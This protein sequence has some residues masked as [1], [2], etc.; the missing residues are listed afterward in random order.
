MKEG[1]RITPAAIYFGLALLLSTLYG[2]ALS[3]VLYEGIF[4]A[5]AWLGRPA[6]ALG[7]AGLTAMAGA[8]LWRLL[9]GHMPSQTVFTSYLPLGYALFWLFDPAIDLVRSRLLTGGSLWLFVAL[10]LRHWPFAPEQKKYQRLLG[11]MLLVLALLPIYLLTMPD[12]VGRADT[13][14]FQVVTPRLGIVHPTGYPLYLILGKLFT[15]VPIGSIAWRLNFSSAVFAIGAALFIFLLGRRLVFQTLPALLGALILGLLPTFWSQAIEAEVYALNALIVAAALYFMAV[16]LPTEDDAGHRH[17][18]VTMLATGRRPYLLLALTLGV[19][20][21]HHLTTLF[22]FPPAALTLWF[23]H[24]LRGEKSYLN[25]R[26]LLQM[27]LLIVAPL[28]F[29]L[30]LPVRWAA[31]NGEPMG[32]A[33][34][35]DWVIGGRFQGALQ[36][37]AWLRDPARFAIVGRLFL[38]E[39]G[40]INLA[41]AA[42]GW[43]ALYH[44]NRRYSFVA[45]LMWGGYTFYS[46]NY[47]V[48][49]LAVFLLPAQIA[50]ALGWLALPALLL[51]VTGKLPT[52]LSRWQPLTALLPAILSLPVIV[53]AATHWRAVDRTADDGRA[54]WGS[55]VLEQPLV[56]NAAI[57]AD[58]ERFPPLYYRQQAEGV[59]PD[60]DIVV[61]PDEDAYRA[62]LDARLAAGQTVYLARQLPGLSGSYH[63]RSAGPLVEV[64]PRPLEEP[65]PEAMPATLTA[66]PLGLVAFEVVVGTAYGLGETDGRPVTAVTLYWQVADPPAEALRVYLRW[67]DSPAT[68]GQH[69]ANNSYPTNAWHPGEVVADFHVL[70]QPLLGTPV[71]LPLQVAVGPPFS[72][73][74]TL[75]WKTISEISLP[76]TTRLIGA[77]PLRITATPG[78]LTGVEVPALVRP[79]SD[80][81]LAVA[82]QG[83]AAGWRVNWADAEPDDSPAPQSPAGSGSLFVMSTILRAP[84]IADVYQV[85]A[86][87]A[88]AVRCGWLQPPASHCPVGS[89]TV[90]GVPLPPDAIN[91]DDK[92]ALLSLAIPQTTLTPGTFLPVSVQWQAL[93][94]LAQDYTVFVQL[95]DGEGRLVGQVDT[96]PV[97]GT[98]PTSR[99]R[100]GTVVADAYQLPIDAT[101]PPGP[102][103]L[104]IGFYL[105]ATGRRLPVLDEAGRPRDDRYIVSGL[106]VP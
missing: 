84:V 93:A 6:G 94:S 101:L 51:D 82:G 102:Y 90:S 57:L 42:V 8:L 104:Q 1:R 86:R 81:M 48:P 28:A 54:A 78:A 24:R 12:G 45:L 3:R 23:A 67:E 13:F 19:G 7:L 60:L 85:E 63:L 21:A 64:S 2:L 103:R 100:P 25:R 97:Q 39:W 91:F 18:P 79:A 43:I 22:L 50:V 11:G 35:V 89:I 105:L 33:R 70:P 44:L 32:L 38:D 20:L 15:A 31:V 47:I 52:W 14:E 53:M 92:I 65:P 72:A 74:E 95:L 10:V 69:P 30:Y 55:A 73:D 29:Y 98:R 17:A 58:S 26:L 88:T 46:L 41:C 71:E 62:E 59:R 16:I 36:W 75:E 83:M 66:G 9:R 106:Y 49:D 4:P 37:A 80:V 76:A 77:Q 56:P 99:W 34:F 40:V 5:A 96:W 68:G 87:G 27:A 61:L